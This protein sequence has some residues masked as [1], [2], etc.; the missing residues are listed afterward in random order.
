MNLALNTKALQRE[1]VNICLARDDANQ[2]VIPAFETL[3][4]TLLPYWICACPPPPPE[5]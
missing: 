5:N 4:S 2:H 3:S 1:L